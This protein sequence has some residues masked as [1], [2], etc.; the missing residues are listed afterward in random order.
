MVWQKGLRTAQTFLIASDMPK[1]F[2]YFT[3]AK[4][5]EEMRGAYLDGCSF[6]TKSPI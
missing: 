1:L 3:T 5:S 6:F 2:A 4:L